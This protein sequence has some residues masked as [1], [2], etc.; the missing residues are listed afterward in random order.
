MLVEVRARFLE[1]ARKT[2][3][4]LDTARKIVKLGSTARKNQSKNRLVRLN[5]SKNL[6][7]NRSVRL[8]AQ[9][10]RSK[11]LVRDG[12]TRSVRQQVQFLLT[13]IRRPREKSID[14]QIALIE[15][16]AASQIV[17][18]ASKLAPQTHQ[19]E[20]KID[21]KRYPILDFNCWSIWAPKLEPPETIWLASA[22]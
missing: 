6:R 13:W 9:K 5:R 19:N 14:R 20:W 22:G 12:W 15:M 3:R 17:K 10:K 8:T 16:P 1:N 11:K 4:L 2:A 18:M 7:N 21:A